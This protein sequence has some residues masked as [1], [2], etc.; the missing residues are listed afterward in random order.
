MEELTWGE[1]FVKITVYG[2]SVTKLFAVK[3]LN[4]LYNM[5]K[6]KYMF[7]VIEL[8][9]RIWVSYL[10]TKISYPQISFII[11][12]LV[13]TLAKFPSYHTFIKAILFSLS[14]N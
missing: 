3:Q 5:A 1:L 14:L 11:K 6:W 8:V 9:I 13:L 12:F 2:T 10:E 7:V 4:T